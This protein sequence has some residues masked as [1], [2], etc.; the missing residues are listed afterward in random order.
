M[1][2]RSS[3]KC[4]G[5]H[6][7]RISALANGSETFRQSKALQQPTPFAEAVGQIP[8][9]ADPTLKTLHAWVERLWLS[10]SETNSSGTERRLQ[11]GSSASSNRGKLLNPEGHRRNFCSRENANCFLSKAAACLQEVYLEV[12]PQTSPSPQMLRT[13]HRACVERTSRRN[14]SNRCSEFDV[15]QMCGMYQCQQAN[16]STVLNTRSLLPGQVIGALLC[17]SPPCHSRCRC[18]CS[19]SHPL[20]GAGFGFAGFRHCA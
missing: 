8:A 2:A 14:S 16:C 15:Q 13:L 5:S 12:A 17:L 11:A 6:K 20:A 9:T 3:E 4:P 1:P 10:L 19:Q 18:C 7:N